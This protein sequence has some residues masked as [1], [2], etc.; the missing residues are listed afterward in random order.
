MTNQQQAITEAFQSETYV[1]NRMDV[2]H[3]PIYDTTTF[4]AGAGSNPTINETTSAFF[5][6]VGA[7]SGKNY[8]QT[9]MDQSVKLTAPEAFSIMALRFRWSEDILRADLTAII[10]GFA[11]QFFL[12]KKYYQRAPI[13]YFGAGGGIFGTT[14][15]T[16][17]SI[18]VNGLPSREAMHKLAIPIVI[19]NQMTFY[20]NL[21]GNALTMTTVASNAAATG[22]TLQLL[23]DG[24]YARGVQ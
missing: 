3:T 12:G 17:E 15:R 22:A 21:S 13:W 19:E 4:T 6:N 1:N 9:N 5:V 8:A 14:T 24:L 7:Q 16:A 18:Y 11:L 20:A 10:N 23:L 2:Q